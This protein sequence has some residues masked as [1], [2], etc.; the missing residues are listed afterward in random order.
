MPAIPFLLRCFERVEFWRSFLFYTYGCFHIPF[1]LPLS[2]HF[3]IQEAQRK[4]RNLTCHWVPRPKPLC[5]LSL[6]FGLL[7][8]VTYIIFRWLTFYCEDRIRSTHISS[9]QKFWSYWNILITVIWLDIKRQTL[10]RN[11]VTCT[12]TE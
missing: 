11:T 9:F 6:S 2:I 5:L 10:Y 12:E 1:Q 3:E 7:I 4:S 8:L